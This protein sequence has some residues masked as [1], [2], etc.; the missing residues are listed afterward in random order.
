MNIDQFRDAI[1]DAGMEPPEVI[2]PGRIQRFPGAG[3]RNGN[4]AAWCK[5][6]NDGQGG[7]FGDWSSGFSG[8]WQVKRDKPL[9]ATERAAFHRHVAEAQAQ[10]EVEERSRH[11]AAAARTAEIL[12]VATDDPVGHPYAIKKKVPLA[13]LV[14]RG[15]WP[16]RGWTDALLVP[17]YGND[18]RLW[19]LEAINVDGD[20]DFLKGGKTSGC[21][22]PFG[23]V[24]GAGRVRSPKD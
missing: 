7:C 12:A 18:G 9:T 19:S 16:Q 10:A 20:K 2:E 3:K 1:R 15:A 21:F 23:Q 8:N 17:I 6:F 4:T 5:L 14:K 24:R 11:E 22:Y 13:P